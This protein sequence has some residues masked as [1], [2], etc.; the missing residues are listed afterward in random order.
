MVA[1]ADNGTAAPAEGAGAPARALTT[2]V[3]SA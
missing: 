2:G 1:S 3:S